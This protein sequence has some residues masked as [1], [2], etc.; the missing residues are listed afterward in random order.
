MTRP[1]TL[2]NNLRVNGI[3]DIRNTTES[4]SCTTGALTVAG[5]VG[6][7]KRLNVCGDVRFTS[8]TASSSSSTGS[9][10]VA[11][12]IGIVKNANIGGNTAI[13][14]NISVGGN[15]AI[16]S[17]LIVS[18]NT[19]LGNENSDVVIVTGRLDVD[20]MRFDGN[21]FSTTTGNIIIDSSGGT[22]I[23]NDNLSISGTTSINGD[24]RVSGDI[25]AFYSSDR[26]LKDN[27][28]RIEDPLAK[29][30]SIS[31]NTYNWNENSGKE[32]NDVGVIAQEVL[33]VLPEAVTTRDNGYLAVDYQRLVP[34]LIEAV[35][36]LSQ[37]VSDLENKLNK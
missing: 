36:E 13:G 16:S 26:R 27:I 32:G 20:N 22:T 21:T 25:T 18:G 9:L 12:G 5:G 31:G 8:A 15:A 23:I 3:V 11:G 17:N 6:I 14:G 10:A 35:K 34:L 30:L 4:T 2:N 1:L 7:R 28:T 29:V 19:S 24:L 37:K 33:E